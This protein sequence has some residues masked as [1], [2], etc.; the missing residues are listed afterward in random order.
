MN[1]AIATAGLPAFAIQLQARLSMADD[2]EATDFEKF[3]AEAREYA[4]AKNRERLGQARMGTTRSAR[5]EFDRPDSPKN[6]HDR[7]REENAADQEK[8]LLGIADPARRETVRAQV[9]KHYDAWG[10]GLKR[11]YN[12]RFDISD[13]GYDR[14]IAALKIEERRIPRKQKDEIHNEAIR[15]A[16]VL[17]NNRIKEI[18]TK[19]PQMIDKAIND[20]AKLPPIAPDPA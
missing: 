13:R 20:A 8:R 1:T 19:L 6:A 17:S 5:P 12:T 16:S 15:E 10:I 9:N 3:K 18:N 7:H 4:A 2:L 11:A 14:K